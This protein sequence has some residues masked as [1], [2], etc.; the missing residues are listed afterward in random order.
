M[1]HRWEWVKSHKYLSGF[2]TLLLV[3]AVLFGASTFY[4]EG[5]IMSWEGTPY[6]DDCEADSEGDLTR[7][8]SPN[9]NAQNLDDLGNREFQANELSYMAKVRNL[10]SGGDLKKPAVVWLY[11]NGLKTETEDYGDL[12]FR[13]VD[14]SGSVRYGLEEGSTC[15]M[16]VNR[17]ESDGE[18]YVNTTEDYKVYEKDDDGDEGVRLQD[19]NYDDVR[20]EAEKIEINGEGQV[21]CKFDYGDIIMKASGLEGELVSIRTPNIPQLVGIVGV[22][23]ET[24]MDGDGVLDSTG[25]DECPETAGI[26]E[27]NGCPNQASKILSVDGPRNVTVGEAVNY[28]VEVRN[29]DDDSTTI[30]WS[31]GGTGE[32]AS[33][34]FNSTG[35]YTVSVSVDDGFTTES[36]DIRVRVEEKSLLGKIVEFFGGVLDFLTFW[37]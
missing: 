14:L 26:P 22:D 33:Y 13:N 2:G 11:N 36:K 3:S 25:G 27:K 34:W 16:K 19:L 37:G 32:S 20:V 18:T 17:I 1:S 12:D 23:F 4:F 21:F 31:N 24:D 35:N 30:S 8:I 9:N 6:Y 29:P 10:E 7:C 15:S 28:S 5:S